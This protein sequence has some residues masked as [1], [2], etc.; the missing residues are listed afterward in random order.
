M[1]TLITRTLVPVVLLALWS[2]QTASAQEIADAYR[3][4]A[5]R[6]IDVATGDH[7]AYARLTELVE[8]FGPRISGS[9]ALER[10]IDWMVEEMEADGFDNVHTERVMVPHWV[11]GEESLEMILPWPRDLPM[12]GLG[13][14][15]ATPPGGIRGEVLVVNSFEEL[16]ARADEAQ[17]RIVLFNVPFTTYGQTVQYRSR[18]AVAAAQEIGRAHV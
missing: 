1:R 17:G 13:F 5:N 4:V 14:S 18:G 12:L 3:D 6:I 2:P 15:V 10:A 11:R 16:E 9:A 8:R 7:D